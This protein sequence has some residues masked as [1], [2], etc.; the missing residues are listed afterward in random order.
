QWEKKEHWVD[1]DCR[2]QHLPELMYIMDAQ[3][4]YLPLRDESWEEKKPLWHCVITQKMMEVL[5]MTSSNELKVQMLFHAIRGLYEE[6]ILK[7]N[8]NGYRKHIHKQAQE[9]VKIILEKKESKKSLFTDSASSS[10]S[11]LT[12]LVNKDKVSTPTATTIT[13]TN[14]ITNG[15]KAVSKKSTQDASHVQTPK[16]NS[17]K[18]KSPLADAKSKGNE[19]T[20]TL[21]SPSSSL[22]SSSP[23]S[24]T[25][26]VLPQKGK[27][28][29]CLEKKF[30]S[31]KNDINTDNS[32]SNNN[33]NNNNNNSNNNNNTNNTTSNN[34]MKSQ[35]IEDSKLSTPHRSS[36][37]ELPKSPLSNVNGNAKVN[38]ITPTAITPRMMTNVS[39]KT[40]ITPKKG[41]ATPRS[42]RKSNVET[43]KES[44][45]GGSKKRTQE[46]ST[47]TMEETKVMTKQSDIVTTAAVNTNIKLTK[48]ESNKDKEIKKMQ[49]M[50]LPI[51]PISPISLIS[52]LGPKRVGISKKTPQAKKVKQKEQEQIDNNT[53]ANANDNGN[54]GN[55]KKQKDVAREEPETETE[56]EPEQEQE[57]ETET[58]ADVSAE[59]YT[60]TDTNKKRMK[61][62]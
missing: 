7:V 1:D 35:S 55:T 33:N 32:N 9:A 49:P 44:A 5:K 10:S 13:T 8:F 24:A 56:T 23:S 27:G 46:G 29:H 38:S 12:S 14:S 57:P 59:S 21:S 26:K 45:S 4:E 15:D 40:P 43:T 50:D 42:N 11:S 20:K 31:K 6:N 22:P 51:S 34:N 58:D 52:P 30:L 47:K 36:T 54:K 17:E 19:S 39:P 37:L 25:P 61:E 28:W 41:I 3:T 62:D 2:P 60:E 53:N 48:K 18:I 16:G